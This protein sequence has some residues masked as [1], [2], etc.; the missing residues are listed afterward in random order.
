MLLSPPTTLC[1]FFVVYSHSQDAGEVVGNQK[2]VHV[3][4]WVNL[5][6]TPM[7]CDAAELRLAVLKK[8]LAP[9]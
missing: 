6:Q 9:A 1:V 5:G 2:S 4:L 3:L 8:L 7:C